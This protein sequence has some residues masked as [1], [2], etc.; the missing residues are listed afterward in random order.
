[1]TLSLVPHEHGPSVFHEHV[2]SIVERARSIA[3]RLGCTALWARRAGPHVLLGVGENEAFARLTPLGGSQVGLAFRRTE[4]LFDGLLEETGATS[5]W[6]PMVFVD[7][8]SD[9]VE[10]ALIAEAV[11]PL[12]AACM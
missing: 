1:M 2:P 6:D 7:D 12:Q 3:R 10:H 4:G 11:L 8:L 9:V 5:C